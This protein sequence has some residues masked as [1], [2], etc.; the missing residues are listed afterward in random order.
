MVPTWS[1]RDSG[2]PDVELYLY[3]LVGVWLS[4]CGVCRIGVCVSSF[5]NVRL[6]RVGV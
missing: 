3:E 5:D 2:S 4:M 6:L 1:H